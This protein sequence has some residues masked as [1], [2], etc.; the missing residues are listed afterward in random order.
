MYLKRWRSG[1]LC[2]LSDKRRE[3]VGEERADGVEK[4]FNVGELQ[5]ALVYDDKGEVEL[6]CK[7]PSKCVA[8]L[9]E[10]LICGALFEERLA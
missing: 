7:G 3:E 5:D 6:V 1:R 10:L 2:E 9:V 8:L 4:L